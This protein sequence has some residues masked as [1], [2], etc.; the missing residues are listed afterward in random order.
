M[1]IRSIKPE[2]WRS[3]DI[4]ALA[5]PDRLL[6][7]GLW[8]YVDDSGVGLDRLADI[9]ADLFALDLERDPLEVYGRVRGG[10]T[11]LS[12]RGLIQRYEVSGKAYLFITAWKRHQR[13]E[14]PTR[15]R[16]PAPTCDDAQFPESSP[17]PPGTL[18]EPSPPGAMEQGNRGTRGTE[19][20]RNT[21][22]TASGA[23]A[24]P[25]TIAL[26]AA[27]PRPA[28]AQTLI[29][30]WLQACT[31]R[32]PSDVIG[33]VG[34]HLKALLDEGLDV[35]DVRNGLVAWHRKGMHPRALSSVVNEVMN[36]APQRRPGQDIDWDSAMARAQAREAI[37]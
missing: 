35:T 2:Y 21:P 25:T 26:I 9:C 22:P 12:G 33:Q 5:I 36:A 4:A 15:S 13:I 3:E 37:A 1:R 32:P 30:E 6:F 24:P 34:K 18:P 7:I 16:N 19:E 27:E 29:D 8:S 31:K 14:K 17:T 20:Q 10:L 28:T 11:E 23:S